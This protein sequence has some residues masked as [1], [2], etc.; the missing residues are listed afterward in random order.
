ML[1]LA[2]AID[3]LNEWLGRLVSWLAL[4]MVIVMTTIVVL[5]YAFAEGMPWQQELVRFMH[6]ILFLAGAAYAL[7][8]EA[9]VRVDVLY[10][11]MCERKQAIVNIIGTV[12]FL[13]PTCFAMIYFT[14]GYVMGSWHILEGSSEYQGMPGVFLFKSFVWVCGAT[15]ALQGVSLII[16]SIRVIKHQEHEPKSNVGLQES[17]HHD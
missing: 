4:G 5:R 17:M 15:V 6:G 8:H 3:G 10:Q 13:F 12:L 7:K 9:L 16:H 2:Q 14:W 11:G 1:K